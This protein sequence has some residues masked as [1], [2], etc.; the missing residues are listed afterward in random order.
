MSQRNILPPPDNYG[1][2]SATDCQTD[3]K[4]VAKSS[5]LDSKVT[6]K[7]PGRQLQ[8]SQLGEPPLEVRWNVAIGRV[9]QGI[10]SKN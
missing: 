7:I 9:D 3:I 4:V 2:H 1:N 5:M 8:S 6:N 10:L